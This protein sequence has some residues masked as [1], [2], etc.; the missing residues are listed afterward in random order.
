MA[1]G[2][3]LAIA[4][5]VAINI[6]VTVGVFR[7]RSYELRQKVL[8]TLI[9][10]LVPVV[11]PLVVGMFLLDHR[12]RAHQVPPDSGGDGGISYPANEI[13]SEGSGGGDHGGGHS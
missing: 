3:A 10:W 6:A 2:F 4:I 11:G 9:A 7:S 5:L 13:F 8:Q 1:S 12:E